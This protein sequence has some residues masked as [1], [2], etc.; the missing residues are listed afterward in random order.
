MYDNLLV[1]SSA[2]IWSEYIF[3]NNLQSL[4]KNKHIT[5]LTKLAVILL[6]KIYFVP[7]IGNKAVIGINKLVKDEVMF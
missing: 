7:K 4:S 1:L 5:D 6:R 3:N 2:T